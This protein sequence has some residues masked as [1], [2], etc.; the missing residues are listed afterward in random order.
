LFASKKIIF[1]EIPTVYGTGALVMHPYV[2]TGVMLPVTADLSLT[3]LQHLEVEFKD[4][5]Y[6]VDLNPTL[7]PSGFPKK[8]ILINFKEHKKKWVSDQT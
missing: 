4:I 2:I 8:E 1:A 6:S 3:K 5:R 7:T